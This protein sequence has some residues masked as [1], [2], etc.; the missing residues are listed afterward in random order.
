M[1]W[2]KL[3]FRDGGSTL[4]YGMLNR[5]KNELG[6]TRINPVSTIESAQKRGVKERVVEQSENAVEKSL[7]PFPQRLQK[8]NDKKIKYE[9]GFKKS[10]DIFNDLYINI[11]L[12]ML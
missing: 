6:E 5:L 10:L 9:A 1:Q 7:P 2:I 11:P 4:K 12:L 8:N 3:N